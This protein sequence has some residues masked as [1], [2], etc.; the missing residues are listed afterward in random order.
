MKSII[1]VCAFLL[2]AT[3]I[4]PCLA[5]IRTIP[6][7][8]KD[9]FARHYPEADSVKFMDNVL[10]VH[11]MFVSNGER[12][13]VTY[14]NKGQWK[15]TEKDWAFDKLDPEIVDGLKKSKFADWSI[16]ETTVVFLPDRSEEYRIKVAKT[17][18]HKRY[19]FF[20]KHGRLLRE[21]VTF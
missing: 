10:N 5:Q 9:S 13:N 12:F 2:M 20:N 1:S 8:V 14:N 11:A 15:Q 18:F 16:K 6:Q 19:L 17:D 4:N 21:S 3:W 7:P